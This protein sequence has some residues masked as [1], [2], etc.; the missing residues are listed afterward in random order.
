MRTSFIAVFLTLTASGALRASNSGTTGADFLNIGVGPRAIAMGDAQVGLADDAYDT[1]YNPAGLATLRTP[2][3]AFTHADYL[4]NISEEYAAY[5]VP[6][7]RWGSFGLSLAYVGYGSF[8]G[9]D[10]VAQP[11]GS[12]GDSDLDLGLSYSRDLYRD[13]RYGTEL[14]AGVTGKWIQERLD[15][16]QATAYAG[17]LGLLF[18]PGIKWGEALNGWKAG[19][20]LR[21]LGTPVTF[22]QESFPLPRILSAGFSYTGNWRNESITLAVDGRQPNDGPR[23]V[24]AGLE[25]WTLQSFVLRG[26]YTTEGDIGNGLRV[27]AGIR[28]KTFQ[29]D[30]AFD[31]EGP[32]GSTQRFGITLRFAAPKPNLSLQAQ[33]QFE[34][35][36]REYKKAHYD[37][38]LLDFQNTLKLDPSH[39]GALD[40]MKKTYEKI[41]EP[42]PE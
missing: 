6:N 34:Q 17:D 8:D 3:A 41:N 35:G 19:V 5:A 30:Y 32:L 22:D 39:P 25:V 14:A 29:V 33:R 40:M 18:A 26:G 16:A 23:S 38:S 9:R 42:Q 21:N 37:E 27:G 4:Q 10:A 12:V 15:T 11:T 24:G 1:Y 31:S 20:A 7:S 28:F 13:D 36:M 2:E